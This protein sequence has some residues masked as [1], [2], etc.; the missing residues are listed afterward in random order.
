[1]IETVLEKTWINTKVAIQRE[2]GD[3]VVHLLNA[4]RGL[5]IT[6]HGGCGFLK[7]ERHLKPRELS[8]MRNLCEWVVN[9]VSDTKAK[10]KGKIAAVAETVIERLYTEQEEDDND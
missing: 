8:E 10:N 6:Y 1:M 9:K 5:A 3:Y 4:Q 7:S 2:C